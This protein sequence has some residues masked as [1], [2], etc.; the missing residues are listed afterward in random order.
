MTHCGRGPPPYHQRVTTDPLNR[1]I[2][3]APLLTILA[4]LAVAAG[5]LIYSRAGREVTET[6]I[7][8]GFGTTP[9]MTGDG[10]K[11]L[12]RVSDGRVLQLTAPDRVLA[13]C[14]VGMRV[15]LLRQGDFVQPAPFACNNER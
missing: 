13:G 12:V 10:P 6:G 3:I 14:R 2:Q 9:G 11:V 7:I 5:S 4:I 15:S 1:R 8:T